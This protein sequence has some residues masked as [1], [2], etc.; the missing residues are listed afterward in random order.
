M[1]IKRVIGITAVMV[2]ALMAFGV[3]AVLAAPLAQ[4][5]DPVDPESSEVESDVRVNA[6]GVT[7]EVMQQIIDRDVLKAATAEALGLTVEELEAAKE[8]GQ[9]ISEIAA[10]QGVELETIQAAVEEARAEMVQDAL[11]EDLITAEQ[12]ECI[13]SHE[14]GLC[15]GRGRGHR[16]GPGGN[17]TAPAETEGASLNA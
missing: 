3:T 2:L 15:G 16:G 6:C 13:L 7:R 12:A 8:S 14:G 10:E 17:E 1:R 4:G 11:D 9:R 5:E